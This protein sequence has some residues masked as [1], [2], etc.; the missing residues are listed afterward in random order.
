MLLVPSEPHSVLVM[1]VN[2]PKIPENRHNFIC[3]E[4][5][6]YFLINDDQQQHL[7]PQKDACRPCDKVEEI[8]LD[9]VQVHKGSRCGIT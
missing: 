3:F 9:K 4:F 2:L 1:L 8:R 6:E 5:L 7:N